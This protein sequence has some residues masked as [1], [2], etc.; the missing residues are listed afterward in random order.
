MPDLRKIPSF[1]F[2]SSGTPN[3][4]VRPTTSA[5]VTGQ[6]QPASS[7]SQTPAQA[8]GSIVPPLRVKK[9]FIAEKLRSQLNPALL[10]SAL[11]SSSSASSEEPNKKTLSLRKSMSRLGLRNLFNRD[12]SAE[13]QTKSPRPPFKLSNHPESEM[14]LYGITN[15]ADLPIKELRT[16]EEILA[17]IE[18]IE[19]DLPEWELKDDKEAS[20]AEKAARDEIDTNDWHNPP[21]TN[22]KRWNDRLTQ[23]KS[24]LSDMKGTDFSR[25]NAFVYYV[26]KKPVGLLTFTVPRASQV[27]AT[28]LNTGLYLHN[29]VTHPGAAACAAELVAPLIAESESDRHKQRGKIHVIAENRDSI[30]AYARLGFIAKTG[31]IDP[32]QDSAEMVLDPYASD[33]WEKQDGRWQ[34]QEFVDE[35]RI[36]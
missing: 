13:Q 27:Y 12:K 5:A 28:P 9:S 11:P 18:E 15:P 36:G 32:N 31:N 2:L 33:K 29:L 24:V 16:K 8:S 35:K 20:D 22:G 17:A 25:N 6:V 26:N 14:D 3:A 7:A 10:E 21:R 1:S 19:A 34:L 4:S 23:T 30:Q